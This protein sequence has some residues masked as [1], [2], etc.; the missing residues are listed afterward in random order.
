[1]DTH[2][3][4]NWIL[5][6]YINNNLKTMVN[7]TKQY[8]IQHSSSFINSSQNLIDNIS[9]SNQIDTST[10][11]PIPQLIM[12][13]SSIYNS[14]NDV[15]SKSNNNGNN[16]NN[17]SSANS[18]LKNAQ[19]VLQKKDFKIK[20]NDQFWDSYAMFITNEGMFVS[21][22]YGLEPN[23]PYRIKVSLNQHWS[24][25]VDIY[26][27]EKL[28]VNIPRSSD[29]SSVKGNI[30]ENNS[31]LIATLEHKKNLYHH[32][33][34]NLVELI[35]ERKNNQMALKKLKKE[36]A[37]ALSQLKSEIEYTKRFIMKDKQNNMKTIKRIQFIKE[38][39]K[40]TEQSLNELEQMGNSISN[41]CEDAEKEYSNQLEQLMK[42]KS[43]FS[44]EIE[45]KRKKMSMRKMEIEE[46]K[47]DL[48]IIK[49]V[50][51]NIET[52][53]LENIKKL[54]NQLKFNDIP[55]LDQDILNFKKTNNNFEDKSRNVI[56]THENHIQD[57]LDKI[58]EFKNDILELESQNNVLLVTISQEQKFKEELKD[59]LKNYSKK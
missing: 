13:N 56:D 39:I 20:I 36:T 59:E 4:V 35:E 37:K 24:T 15:P 28:N 46:Y 30:D 5:P 9:Y 6:E 33:Q 48:D 21:I 50:N 52:V 2:A 49:Q 8:I 47:K 17:N 18:F 23:T 57:K 12:E 16:S 53:E 14:P 43:T 54:I 58:S 26:T 1:M 51:H 29:Q 38:Y 25:A 41:N 3:L 32:L 31:S 34:S 44:K 55:R 10:L 19:V 40:Q 11:L 7:N 42:Q 27:K 45:V 22:I